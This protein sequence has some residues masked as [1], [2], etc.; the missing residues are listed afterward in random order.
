MG[1]MPP[2]PSAMLLAWSVVLLAMLHA[3]GMRVMLLSLVVVA[4]S[5][6]V[7][8][9]RCLGLL[10]R[11]RWLLLATFLAFGWMT[12]GMPVAGLPGATGD[13][14]YLAMEQTARLAISI[15]MTAMLLARFDFPHLIS[16]LRGV[17]SPL[18]GLGLD[19][20]RGVLRLALVLEEFDRPRRD[21]GDARGWSLLD[22]STVTGEG[23]ESIHVATNRWG[24]ADACLLLAAVGI[25]YAVS[26]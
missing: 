3:A 24:V 10:R 1:L 22:E 19:I 21:G 23:I 9:A 14:L 5:M 20:D 26:R 7:A 2:R 16:A 6:L 8:R 4:L 11:S 12:P 13:G 15:A 17:A 25:A 18:R